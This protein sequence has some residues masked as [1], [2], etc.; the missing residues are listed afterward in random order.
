V[1]QWGLE[2]WEQA[3]RRVLV[4]EDLALSRGIKNR[5]LLFIRALFE[6]IAAGAIGILWF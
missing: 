1:R 4:F 2:G 6:E 3:K 5:S